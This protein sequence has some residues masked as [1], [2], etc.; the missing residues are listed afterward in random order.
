MIFVWLRG[1]GGE[2][3]ALNTRCIGNSSHTTRGKGVIWEN[4]KCEMW[5]RGCCQ[6]MRIAGKKKKDNDS[7]FG[8]ERNSIFLLEKE[9]EELV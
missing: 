3:K 6:V 9:D 2:A 8:G 4:D 1:R 5:T 7:S